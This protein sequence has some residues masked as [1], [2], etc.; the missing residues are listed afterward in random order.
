MKF[1]VLCDPNVEIHTNLA[2]TDFLDVEPKHYG[3][4]LRCPSCREFISMIPWLPPHRAELEVWGK[5]YG[6]IA[7]G[8]GDEELVSERFVNLYRTSGL[9]GL[10]VF[11]EVEITKV[12]RRGGSR[13]RNPPPKY[14]CVTVERSRAAID[15]EASG[16]VLEEPPTCDVCKGGLIIRT[17]RV[18]LEPETWSGEDIFF[19]RGLPGNIITSE[20][21]KEFF[22]K[23]QI[24][25]GILVPAEEFSFDFYPGETVYS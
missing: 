8:S 25:N 21:F 1:Y 24:N 14:Y 23:N 19:A 16:L 13:L 11:H 20:R 15:I 17:K 10:G 2:I 6:D 22:E 12:I 3:E 4:A 18:I 9:T 7:F 5:A